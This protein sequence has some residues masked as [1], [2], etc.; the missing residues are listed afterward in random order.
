MLLLGCDMA[1]VA[2]GDAPSAPPDGGADAGSPLADPALAPCPEGWAEAPGPL[3]VL[4]C[5]PWPLGHRDDCAFDEAHFPGGPGCERIGTACP[6][7][8][9]RQG[10]RRA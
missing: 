2:C 9:W 7:D 1:A 10:P 8:G 6:A 5:E 4:V 3:G